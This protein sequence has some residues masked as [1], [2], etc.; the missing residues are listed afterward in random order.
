MLWRGLA[1]IQVTRL[2]TV[3]SQGL[4][5]AI[6]WLF[7][8]GLGYRTSEPPDWRKPRPPEGPERESR[9]VSAARSGYLQAIDGGGLMQLAKAH[10][11]ALRVTPRPGR[12][13]IRGS[14]LVMAAMVVGQL[15]GSKPPDVTRKY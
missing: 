8:D 1:S 5:H 12:F 14:V 2:I 9:P 4:L 6:A 13:V 11:L 3:V 10:D 7:P 15:M